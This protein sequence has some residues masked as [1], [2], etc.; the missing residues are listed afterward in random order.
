MNP[1]IIIEV[2]GRHLHLSRADA[3][4][5]FG[6]GYQLNVLKHTSQPG[7]FAAKET[8]QI[9]GPKHSFAKVRVVGPWR[10]QTQLELS[11]T[12]CLMLGVAPKIRVSGEFTDSSGGVK[13]VGP[14]GQI[15]LS[16]GIIVAQRH[17]HLSPAQAK[18]WGL[19]HLDNVSVRTSGSR[20]LIFKNVVVRSRPGIDELSFMI[21][22]DEANA[23]GVAQGDKGELLL[24][25]I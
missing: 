5:L 8:V 6:P 21:D 19:K 9:V 20:A 17:L 24:N 22:T 15:K 18:Q 25:E 4:K 2:S 13:V 14:A 12:D 1:K 3:D 10:S 23:A 11:T 7:Q 16:A